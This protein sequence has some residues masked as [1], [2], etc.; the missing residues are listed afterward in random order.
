M[1][2]EGQQQLSSQLCS[3]VSL[4]IQYLLLSPTSQQ[5]ALACGTEQLLALHLSAVATPHFVLEASDGLR[6]L[7]C[8]WRVV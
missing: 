8:V 3:V 7:L 1:R 2:N 5:S 6:V 4:C